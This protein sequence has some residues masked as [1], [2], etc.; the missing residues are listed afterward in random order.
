MLKHAYLIMEHS[1]LPVAQA[2]LRMI[3]DPR[4]EIFIYIDGNEVH[5]TDFLTQ[6]APVHFLHHHV[7]FGWG[8][9]LPVELALLRFASSKGRFRY[10]HLLSDCCLP[11][12]SQDEIHAYFDHDREQMIYLHVNR[13]TFKSIQRECQTHYP[14]LKDRNFRKKKWLKLLAKIVVRVKTVFGVNRLRRNSE[15]PVCYNGWQWFSFPDDFVRYIVKKEPLLKK[16][17]TDVLAN[18]EDAF[19]SLGMNSSFRYRMY[20][21]D[22]HD[23]AQNASKRMIKWNTAHWTPL[24]FTKDD[25]NEIVHNKNCFFARKF[26]ANVDLEIVAMLENYVRGQNK[27]ETR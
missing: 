20:G 4:N 25:F 7:D 1:N 12:K 9:F 26:Y 19:Q 13:Y 24:V 21:Y 14:F 18:E 6:H 3:D 2:A 27:N 22:G 23:D 11:I 16:T 10:Y 15:I 17:F 5:E 8:N